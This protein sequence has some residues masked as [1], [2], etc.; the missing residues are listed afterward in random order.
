MILFKKYFPNYLKKLL[1]LFKDIIKNYYSKLVEKE[2]A[3]N[4]PL[5]S[6]KG[7]ELKA[8][9]LRNFAHASRRLDN[10]AVNKVFGILISQQQS[11]KD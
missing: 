6:P 10:G 3:Q 5:C 2:K 9:P 1:L 7:C 8:Q 4:P 11:E